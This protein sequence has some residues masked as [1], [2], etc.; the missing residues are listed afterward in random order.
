[1]DEIKSLRI[2]NI[3]FL[4]ITLILMSFYRFYYHENYYFHSEYF[5]I[6]VVSCIILVLSM[7]YNTKLIGYYKK[8]FYIILSFLTILTTDVAYYSE[9]NHFFSIHIIMLLLC[10][11]AINIKKIY[12]DF[13]F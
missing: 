1:M 4:I 6:V 12:D 5:G 13:Y 9:H 2:I 7:G 10:V 3:L 8:T 11:F